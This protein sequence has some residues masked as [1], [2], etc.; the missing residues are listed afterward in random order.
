MTLSKQLGCTKKQEIKDRPLSYEAANE[1]AKKKGREIAPTGNKCKACNSPLI[2]IT[3]SVYLGSQW[4][5]KEGYNI[6]VY[7]DV[8]Q[9]SKCNKEHFR[10]YK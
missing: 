6:S 8:Y 9:C 7:E 5:D 3:T 2:T 1:I 10:R 4:I